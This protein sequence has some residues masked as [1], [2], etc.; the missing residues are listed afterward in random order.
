[1]R[2]TLRDR[3]NDGSAALLIV[4]ATVLAVGFANSS[5]GP[6]LSGLLDTHLASVTLRDALASGALLLFFTMAGVELRREFSTGLLARPRIAVA[7]VLS[8]ALGMVVPAVLFAA[9]AG[10]R[11]HGFWGLAIATDL[12]LALAALSAIGGSGLT[13]VRTYV[14]ALAVMDDVF[15]VLVL[16]IAFPHPV[17]ILYLAGTALCL[18]LLWLAR[19]RNMPGQVIAAIAAIAWLLMLRS[20]IH[21]PCWVW[22]SGSSCIR[23]PSGRTHV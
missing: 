18:T 19:S 3:I 5:V 22:P 16:S 17:H 2:S 4:V 8:A 13:R 20:G 7:V 9:L 23:C 10:Q 6:D 14:L 1:V 11:W 12:P 15:S 21:A